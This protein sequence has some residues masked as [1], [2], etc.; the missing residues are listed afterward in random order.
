V[1]DETYGAAENISSGMVEAEAR[2]EVLREQ[3]DQAREGTKIAATALFKM[4]P[5]D[6]EV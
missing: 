3:I 5:D 4:H 2:N 1:D 6:F